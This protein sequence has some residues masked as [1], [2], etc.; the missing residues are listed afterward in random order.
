MNLTTGVEGLSLTKNS[1]H[2]L[3][4]RDAFEAILQ[5]VLVEHPS[6]HYFDLESIRTVLA[7]VAE[8]AF[9]AYNA[10]LPFKLSMHSL[11]TLQI[12]RLLYFDAH[13]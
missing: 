2:R 5:R 9:L 1:A 3:E 7:L 6:R 4:I 10:A 11:D 13:V 8:V 12:V